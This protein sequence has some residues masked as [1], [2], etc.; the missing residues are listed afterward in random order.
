MTTVLD[1][2]LRYVRY[3]TQSDEQSRT[4]PSTEKQLVLL[5]DLAGELRSVGVADASVDD[6]GYVMA[7]IPATSARADVPTIGFI[8]HVDTSPEMSGANVKPIVHAR[9]DGRDLLLPDDPSAV[10]TLRDNPA[11]AG[12]NG[13]DIVTASGTTLLGA[14]NKAGVAEIVTAAGYLIAHPEIPHGR[15]RIAFT[16]DEEIGRGTQHFDVARFGAHC[17]YT[18]DGGSRG[19]I[20]MESFSADAITVTFH[21]FN[22]H[23]GFARGRMV[24]AIKLAAAF[25]ERLPHDTMSPETTGGYE[26]FLHPY[27][28]HAAV[29][30]TSVKLL[31]RDFVTAALKDKEALVERLARETAAAHPGAR[32]DLAVEES[33]RNMKEV[34]DHHPTVVEHAREAIRRAGLEPRSRPIRGG[35]DGS[36]LSFVGLPTPNIFAGEHNFHSR[37]EWV[38]VQD[39]EKAVEVIVNL[40]RVWE[41]TPS[42]VNCETRS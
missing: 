7:T 18:M 33:Y 8:A 15:I 30:Q 27:V 38:S 10:L 6:Y 11:L 32:V 21:G 31:V 39:M 19:E 22:T 20:E 26:G 29:E 42:A 13:H 14:D 41:E 23:P 5:R 12:Q 24:N 9:Y 16:P 28:V 1:R 3:D 36:R 25:I 2:F 17:A 35:T 37:L 34:L 40:R 4:F